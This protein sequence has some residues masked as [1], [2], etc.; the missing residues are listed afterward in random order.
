M[1]A[2]HFAVPGDLDTLTGG[3]IY[4]RRMISELRVA[5]RPVIVHR[6]SDS[7]PHPTPAALDDAAETLAALED[8]VSVVID[9]LAFGAMPRIARREATRLRLIALVHHPLA[10]E[11]G[12]RPEAQDRLF[13][14]E[15]AALSTA[16]RII[17]TSPRT[18]RDLARYGVPADRIGTVCPGTDPAPLAAG[19]SGPERQLLCVATL[20]PRKGHD[21]LLRALGR[22]RDRPWQLVCAGS[23]MRAPATAAAIRSLITEVALDRRVNLA[24][25]AAGEE[26]EAL[27][28]GADLFVLASHLEGY[29]MALAEA[30]ARG[31][32]VVSTTAGAI[33]DT[34][35]ADA[36]L[37]VPPGDADALAAALGRVLDDDERLARLADGA[38]RAR[39]ALPT[40]PAA[41]RR[42]AAEVLDRPRP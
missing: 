34:V 20:T 4:D 36:G 9:G 37:L 11:T 41:A 7:F 26:L 33:P 21:I 6:L 29:G 40:W 31:L 19:S 5:S 28:H 13:R 42:F 16:H 8:G 39:S 15:R 1:S 12:L 27:Y 32:P 25:E 14:D 24:G 17:T 35:P 3:Y 38:R 2:L 10:A 23:T 18:A 30:L 22:I